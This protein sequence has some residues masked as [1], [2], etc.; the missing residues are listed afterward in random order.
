MGGSS[1]FITGAT[2]FVGRS[3]VEKL[4]ADPARRMV[5][6]MR[7]AQAQSSER[8]AYVIGDLVDP[9]SYADSLNGC[10]TVLHLA[11]ATGKQAPGEY[12][13]V[14]R[15]GTEALLAEAERSGAKRFIYISSI[16]AKFNDGSYPYG[17]SKLAAEETVKQSKLRWTIVRPTMV[18]GKGSA[19]L[20]SL[21][22]LANLP[23][24]P[25]FGDGTIRVQPVSVGDLARILVSILVDET[26][27]SRILE[28]GGPEVVS[29]EDLMRSIR[30][31]KLARDGKA[32]HLPVGAVAAC[33]S[34]VEPVLRPLLP[35]TAGQLASFR[36]EGVAAPDPWI[37][38]RRPAMKR[39][40]DMLDDAA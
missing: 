33:L 40:K 38:R 15:D 29:M 27:D 31:A 18:L 1:I 24:M 2:G 34:M 22:R 8:I 37:E 14:N 12:F 9:K 16:A 13:R 20:V 7:H 39:V 30:W 25:I 10:D 19:V 32:V 6:L 36:H 5:C 23:A 35:F 4:A 11:A 21:S 28:V 26:L 17:Q 3:V